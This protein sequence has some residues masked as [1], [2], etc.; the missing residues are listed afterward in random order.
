MLAIE[1]A[2]ALLILAGVFLSF[3]RRVGTVAISAAPRPAG[4]NYLRAFAL[5]ILIFAGVTVAFYWEQLRSRGEDILFFGWLLLAMVAGMF[6]QVMAE[7]YRSRKRLFDIPRDRLLY[8]LLF[9]VIVFYP[10]WALASSSEPNFF[11]V[12]AA[13]LNGYFWESIVSAARP[14][15]GKS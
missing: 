9:S 7:N 14:S 8:P 11:V 4:V 10:V 6:A 13:F 1:I 2:T 3:A 15:S 12:Q 5:F